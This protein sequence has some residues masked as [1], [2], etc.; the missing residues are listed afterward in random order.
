MLRPLSR[1]FVYFRRILCF[2]DQTGQLTL[3]SIIRSSHLWI[4]VRKGVLR[5]IVKFSGKHLR[6]SL[7]FFINLQALACNFIKKWLWHGCFPVDFEKFLRA[8]FSYNT[9]ERL[10]FCTIQWFSVRTLSLKNGSFARLLTFDIY[11]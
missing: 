10:C 9:S 3:K 6:Q 11:C 4:S 7:F 2:S 8:P 5:N 1:K